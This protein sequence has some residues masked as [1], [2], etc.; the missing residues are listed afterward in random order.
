MSGNKIVQHVLQD[1]GGRTAQPVRLQQVISAIF[2]LYS[3]FLRI[4]VSHICPFK[5]LQ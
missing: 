2:V 3:V 5:H 1:R 4:L